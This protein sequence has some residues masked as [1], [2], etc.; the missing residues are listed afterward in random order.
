MCEVGTPLF[1]INVLI[2]LAVARFLHRGS[3]TFDPRSHGAGTGAISKASIERAR[4]AFKFPA[5]SPDFNERH[6][7]GHWQEAYTKLHAE[8]LSGQR[9]PRYAVSVAVEAGLADRL[10]GLIT[11]FYYALLSGR[12]FK[13]I[14]Y[15]QLPGYERGVDARYVSK[16]VLV[17]VHS[18]FRDRQRCQI[19]IH[20]LC[21]P[22]G[23]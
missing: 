6:G 18:R 22:P 1:I 9:P 16:A 23:S 2:F 3:S 4:V 21:M 17:E 14:T 8:I 7:C 15:G 11:Q 5:D 13:T 10:S 20:T 12:A 19:H